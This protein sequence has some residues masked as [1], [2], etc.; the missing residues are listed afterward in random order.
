ML[1]DDG[2]WTL[3]ASVFDSVRRVEDNAP[4]HGGATDDPIAFVATVIGKNGKLL[5]TNEVTVLS[6]D[7]VGLVSSLIPHPSSLSF[8]AYQNLW[9]RTDTKEAQPVIKKDVKADYDFGDSSDYNNKLTLTLKKDGVVSFAG[10][11][12]GVSVSGSSQL[13]YG[14]NGWQVTLYAPPKPKAKPAFEG[15]CKTFAVTLTF[16]ANVAI[17]A[18]LAE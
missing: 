14:E 2:T 5:E 15:W 1:R 13:V 7:G 10:K 9:K 16:D 11:V 12:G 6:S 8:T 4:Y 17:G 18:T 3:S